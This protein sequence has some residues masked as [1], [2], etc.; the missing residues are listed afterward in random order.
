MSG[1]D[2]RIAMLDKRVRDLDHKIDRY[3][4]EQ[5]DKLDAILQFK[6]QLMGGSLVVTGLITIAVQVVSALYS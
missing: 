5:N 1:Y 2:Q 4:K 3:N 6:W